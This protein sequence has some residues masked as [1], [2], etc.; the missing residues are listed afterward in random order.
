M[1]YH[2][3]EKDKVSFLHTHTHAHARA[4][5]HTHIH[6]IILFFID[7]SIESNAENY[8]KDNVMNKK[9]QRVENNVLKEYKFSR[10]N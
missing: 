7:S 5:T 4:R 8:V 9:R 3:P 6:Y 2:T 10:Y 1:I